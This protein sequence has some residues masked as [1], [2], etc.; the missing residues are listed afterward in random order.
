MEV[1]FTRHARNRMRHHDWSSDAV[2]QVV[3][4]AVNGGAAVPD[5]EHG[6]LRLE[7]SLGGKSVRVAFVIED[8]RIVVKSIFPVSR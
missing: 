3:E 4:S 2:A 7:V 5:P 6:G 1:R 8:G